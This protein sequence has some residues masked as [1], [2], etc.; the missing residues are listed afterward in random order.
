MGNRKPHPQA[1][2]ATSDNST[3]GLAAPQPPAK[4]V[5]PAISSDLL[6]A[7]EAARR[8]GVTVTTLYDWLGQSDFGLLVI[9]GQ[10]VTIDYLQG[11]PRGQGRIR[12]PVS[13]VERVLELM[14]VRP[15]TFQP[16]RRPPAPRHVFPHIDVPLGL[17]D[18]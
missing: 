2:A 16:V 5:P 8:L 7:K 6:S 9:R 14:R 1:A 4:W 13:E 11:G 3:D 15:Q 17:P 18:F 10:G 12:I